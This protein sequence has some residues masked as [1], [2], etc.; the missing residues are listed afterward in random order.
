ME[1]N[2]RAE[3]IYRIANYEDIRIADEL[4]GIPEELF[5]DGTYRKNIRRLQLLDIEIAYLEYLAINS[6]TNN[7]D[8]P[9]AL[10]K[11]KKLKE[12]EKEN[13]LRNNQGNE[14]ATD[15]QEN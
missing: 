15:L 5:S 1:R 6:I 8:L 12:E 14:T 10:E 3:R 11:L 13:A 9:T 2:L 4:T 7:N